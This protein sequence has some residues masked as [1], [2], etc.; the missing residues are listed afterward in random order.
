MAKNKYNDALLSSLALYRFR[1]FDPL[2][3][4]CPK[5]EKT[6][7]NTYDCMFQQARDAFKRG[8]F[9]NSS[10]NNPHKHGETEHL[11]QYQLW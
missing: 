3:I 6:P 7:C 8:D 5:W 4:K 2:S 9:V 10:H 1:A 11:I